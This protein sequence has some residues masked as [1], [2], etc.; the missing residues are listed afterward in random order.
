MKPRRTT[1][2]KAEQALLKK[3]QRGVW[4]QAQL[5]WLERHLPPDA[6]TLL[7]A[8]VRHRLQVLQKPPTSGA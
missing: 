4:A 7:I 3:L 8:E 5:Q 1:L 6:P 2:T